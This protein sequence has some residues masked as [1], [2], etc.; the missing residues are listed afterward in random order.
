MTARA[1]LI[2]SV[3]ALVFSMAGGAVAASVITGRQIKNS[4]LTG[5]DIKNRS[6][7]TSDLSTKTRTGLTGKTGPAGP[8]G[9]V[10]ATGPAG[11]QGPAGQQGAAGASPAVAYASFGN[12]GYDATHSKN[13][14]KTANGGSSYSV[15]IDFAVPVDVALATAHENGTTVSTLTR[16]GNGVESYCPANQGYDVAVFAAQNGNPIQGFKNFDVV[17]Y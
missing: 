12:G 8:A 14:V 4:S 10:G 17:G 11:S 13:V 3:V 2:V 5:A 16:Q 6:L 15:C 9:A 7:T 1:A